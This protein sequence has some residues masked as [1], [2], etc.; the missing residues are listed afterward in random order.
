[1]M[2]A[3]ALLMVIRHKADTSPQKRPPKKDH[4]PA[5]EIHGAMVTPGNPSYCLASDPASH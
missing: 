2:L 1:V 4:R 3:F 5:S